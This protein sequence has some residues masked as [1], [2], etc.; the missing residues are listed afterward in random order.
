MRNTNTLMRSKTG[1]GNKNMSKEE[2]EAMLDEK[3]A[4]GEITS[5]EAEME[6]QDFM[7]R[8][9]DLREW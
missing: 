7:H 9:D 6:W 1:K 4:K 8:N 2:F 5:W 3:L